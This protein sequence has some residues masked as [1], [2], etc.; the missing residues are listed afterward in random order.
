[1]KRK[2]R[3]TRYFYIVTYLSLVLV[4]ALVTVGFLRVFLKNTPRSSGKEVYDKYYVLITDDRD[5]TFWNSV[6]T[7]ASNYGFD[8]KVYVENLGAN[9][10]GDLSKEELMR[11]AIASKVDGII[12]NAEESETMKLLINEATSA[13]IPV[14]TVNNDCLYSD[15]IC[16]VGIG[17]YNLG[18]EYGKQISNIANDL[19]YKD[20]GV[21]HVAVLVNSVQASGQS[22]IHSGIQ[23]YIETAE[24]INATV[25]LEMVTVDDKNNFSVEESIRDLFIGEDIPD[26]I[27]CLN[28]LDTTCVYQAVI[29]Y[30]NVG[31]VHIL[32]YYDSSTVLQ[33]IDRNI[34]D[35]TI[36]IDTE[37]MGEYC[38]EALLSYD[39]TG[40]ANQYQSVDITLI[41]NTNIKSYLSQ[42]E[43]N[44]ETN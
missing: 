38:V 3:G 5:S 28:E 25:E 41:N 9:L 44:D 13:S 33:G 34:I 16:Y 30:N 32:G 43:E 29:D 1:M 37:E 7:G 8:H 31:Q 21:V 11:I 18:K 2:H 10:S 35:S 26:I 40:R 42:Q 24:N 15:R 4:T 36:R 6:Y 20:A 23:E 19:L 22:I 14:V 17:N 39:R 27:V 12:L